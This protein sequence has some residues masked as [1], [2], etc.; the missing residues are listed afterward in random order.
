MKPSENSRD[1]LHGLDGWRAVA[2]VAVLLDH[3]PP[4][5][6][7]RLQHHL[8]TRGLQGVWL[9]FAISGFLICTRLLDEEGRHGRISLRNFYVRRAFRILPAA[10]VYLLTVA[11]LGA[12]DVIPFSAGSWRAALLF[13]QNYWQ[14]FYQATTPLTAGSWFT[15]HFWSLSVEEHFYFLLPGILLLFPLARRR[16]L[17]LLT[18]ISFGWLA[19]FLFGSRGRELPV[20]WQLRT[21]FCLCALL[22]PAMVA[23]ALRSPAVKARAKRWLSPGWVCGVAVVA[24]YFDSPWGSSG[25]LWCEMVVGR[26]L[27]NPLV[28]VATVLHPMSWITRLLETAPVKFVGRIS[29]SL[30]LWQTLFLTRTAVYPGA[31]HALQRPLIGTTCAV[32]CALASYY[33]V[34]MPMIRLGRRFQTRGKPAEVAAL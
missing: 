29:Y 24:A 4:F 1:Y 11:L 6:P 33:L 9:F 10:M 21:E 16:I 27:L 5:G 3:A 26:A 12:V 2:V 20:C 15:G 19:I 32:V 34:E 23:I 30:Y 7:P 14:Y 18:C 22:V 13:Y 8:Q 17:L 25:H 31:I 28:L